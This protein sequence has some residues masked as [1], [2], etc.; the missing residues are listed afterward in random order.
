M[1]F[2]IPHQ[3]HGT[4]RA[5]ASPRLLPPHVAN[6]LVD[7]ARLV[8]GVT[9]LV[10]AL[11]TWAS[12]AS[13]SF[14]DPSLSNITS[15]VPRN[16]LGAPGAMYADLLIQALGLAV[17][18][19]LL[20]PLFW[21]AAL[22]RCEAVPHAVRRLGVYTLSVLAAA[23]AASSLPTFSAW[24]L[25][26]G[27]GGIFGDAVLRLTTA[28]F[29]LASVNIGRPVVGC[30]MAVLALRGLIYAIGVTGADLHALTPTFRV[31]G[32]TLASSTGRTDP[33]PFGIDPFARTEPTLSL[34]LAPR[35]APPLVTPISH[36]DDYHAQ[37][38]T[39]SRFGPY[40]AYEPEPVADAFDE[41][42]EAA[43]SGMAARFAPAANATHA[44]QDTVQSAFASAAHF[45]EAPP[46]DEPQPYDVLPPD[47]AGATTGFALTRAGP[48]AVT[49]RRP[50]LNL[51]ERQRTTRVQPGFAASVL[52]G[53][54]R[55][56]ED[57]LA[58]FGVI[59]AVNDIKPGPVVTLYEFAPA[60]GTNADRVIALGPDVARQMG[61][62]SVRIAPMPG[63]GTLAIELPNQ[64][65]ETVY[66]RDIFDAEAYR[67]T[68]D[69]LPVALGRSAT[70]EV[71]VGCL[72]RMPHLLMAGAHGAGKT[73]GINAIILSLVYKHGP[74]NCRF[75]MIDPKMMELSVFDGIPHLL[76]P[77]VS[78]PH[79]AITALAWCV[80]E[81]EERTKQMAA[82]GVRSIDVF[83]NRVRNAKKRGE[84][85]ART[86][87]TGFDDRTGTA[88]FEKEEM[89]LEVLPYIVIVIEEFADLMAVAGRELEGAV[90]RLADAA[91]P[92]GIH[93]I[94]AT[95]RPT[96]DIVTGALKEN[97]ATRLAYKLA[98]RSDSRALLSVEG[99]EHLLGA[100][101]MLYATGGGQAVRLHGPFVSG[102]EVETI[103]ASLRENGA[104]RYVEGL[105]DD[106]AGDGQAHG[107]KRTAAARSAHVPAPGE[108][109]LYDRAV[110][111]VVRDGRTSPGL[112]QRR[113]NI[114]AAWA[115]GLIYRLETEGILGPP[116][117]TGV[118]LALVGAAA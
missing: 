82:L 2:E 81:M 7:A 93:L 1:A 114:S 64:L 18:G 62:G 27:L 91:R 101:D 115:A 29:H 110:A 11:A 70:G 94:M 77:V 58:E 35:P 65:R 31:T 76:T 5:S 104:P 112:L 9:V 46:Q 43:S 96:S 80:R 55:L 42:T 71:I 25:H 111:L 41:W 88:T 63:R 103:A 33:P 13:W 69:A 67:S 8:A 26:P 49:Y 48:R 52:R 118:R 90:K 57:G 51:L 19:A 99:A 74:E 36:E 72:T 6:T 87:Q 17:L 22:V 21:G 38:R 12:L 107:R 113:L 68:M 15:S 86:V 50:S 59:G 4:R 56:L 44:L 78:D 97:L 37:A 73:V 105:T 108:D 106:A 40:A 109:A 28:P 32:R 92:A 47:T 16:W 60:R 14:S 84:R 3:G 117:P 75:L 24:P 83:N 66:L 61:V 102:E 30:I 54:A 98:S 85:I 53:N 116:D 34:P 95:E 39:A 45:S 20:P 89:S 10:V 23:T 79:K 100:G